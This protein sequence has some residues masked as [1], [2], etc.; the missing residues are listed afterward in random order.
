MSMMLHNTNKV[1]RWTLMHAVFQLACH[2]LML[3]QTRAHQS[4]GWSG[5]VDSHARGLAA[6]WK[7]PIVTTDLG[8]FGVG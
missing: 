4:W 8:S 7:H 1:D 6:C 3:L 2:T 5:L